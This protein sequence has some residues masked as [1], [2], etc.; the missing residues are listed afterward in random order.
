MIT[1]DEAIKS[2]FDNNHVR[3]IVNVMYTANW[4]KNHH[5]EFLSE[6]Q[7]SGQQY[8]IL[9]I[10]RGAKDFLPMTEVKNRMIE[11]SPNTTRLADKLLEATYIERKRC[12]SDRRVVYV[13]ITE[14]G[15]AMLAE[16]D[17]KKVMQPND[18]VKKHLSDD[19]ARMLSHLLDKLRNEK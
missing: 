13:K 1:I 17:S 9:R 3:A 6:Y 4:Y 12:D 2:K 19:E 5:Q 15:L 16:I 8:N 18:L 7:I 11:K 14:K 10:L